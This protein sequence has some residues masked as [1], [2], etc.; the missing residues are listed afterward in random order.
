MSTR[1]SFWAT[2]YYEYVLWS[3][4]SYEAICHTIVAIYVVS[5][6]VEPRFH[7]MNSV[8]EALYQLYSTN[9]KTIVYVYAYV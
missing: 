9:Y 8:V 2:S 4:G 3:G 5:I 1:E 7:R 6:R